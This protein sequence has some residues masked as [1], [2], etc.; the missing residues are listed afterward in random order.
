VNIKNT[1][2]LLQRDHFTN[3]LS[4]RVPSKSIYG[5]VSFAKD[6]TITTGKGA[7][8]VAMQGCRQHQQ[9]YNFHVHKPSTPMA[10]HAQAA[11][12][13]GE[14]CANVDQSRHCFLW[15]TQVLARALL[16]SH[17]QAKACSCAGVTCIQC[18]LQ[19][20]TCML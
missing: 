8:M 9:R 18:C 16:V 10:R 19:R 1:V 6:A 5:G 11:D 17:L 14:T 13:N 3:Y 7:D 20:V 15:D 4:K 12:T 2:N